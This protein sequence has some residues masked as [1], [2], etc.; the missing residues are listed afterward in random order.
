MR[1][2]LYLILLAVLASGL[3]AG[4]QRTA[5]KQPFLDAKVTSDFTLVGGDISFG[6]YD[7][8]FYW[9]AGAIMDN[10]LVPFN[11]NAKGPV[12]RLTPYGAFMYRLLRTNNRA[13]NL[14]GGGDVFI[15]AEFVDLFQ[16]HDNITRATR[17]I[18]GG[19]LRIEGEFF[20]SMQLAILVP[21]RLSIT[22]NSSTNMVWPTVG[23]GARYNF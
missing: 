11:D 22:G 16:R 10:F 1:K 8:H 17:F 23:L 21:V 9:S 20:V 19:A 12:T 14:Y 7:R 13:V 4:A 3:T 2:R 6:M 15:G 5:Y 18:Y